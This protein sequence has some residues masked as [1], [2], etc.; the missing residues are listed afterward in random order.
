MANTPIFS[1]RLDPGIKGAMTEIARRDS[2]SLSNLIN[3]ALR[4]YIE[5]QG[6]M[7]CPHCDGAGIIGVD[8]DGEPE[9]CDAC[10]GL[11]YVALKSEHSRQSKRRS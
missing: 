8:E 11:A 10:D 3:K 5:G 7:E 6:F 4:E 1:L 9:L 2:R